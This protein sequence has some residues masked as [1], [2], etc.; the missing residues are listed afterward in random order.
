MLIEDWI[1]SRF[2]EVKV[3]GVNLRVNCPY[4]G[5]DTK[6]HLY[7]RIDGEK[8]VF[9]CFRCGKAG[10]HKTLV[11]YVDNISI[12]AA[13]ALIES[14]I[15]RIK[16]VIKV[17]TPKP[18]GYISFNDNPSGIEAKA[19]IRYLK[20]RGIPEEIIKTSCGIVPGSYRSWFLFDGF[21]QGRSIIN[22]LPKY[23]SPDFPKDGALWNPDALI[24]HNSITICEGIIS[25]IHAGSNAIGL[26]GKEATDSQITRIVH[27]DPA[28][29]RIMLDADA[30]KYSYKLAEKLRYF[31]Y[32][33]YIEIA[34]LFFGDPADC[35]DFS[36]IPYTFDNIVSARLS[37]SYI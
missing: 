1:Y 11:A 32:A 23:I 37:H 31:G 19:I 5:D 34:E 30:I 10:I 8:N 3:S 4:C 2:P 18:E 9:H 12:Y 26:L 15:A 35:Q 27:A 29:I 17:K 14:S 13:E 21:W 25:A 7:I 20:G 6:G 33:R 22:A 28:S 24:G 16:P 36:I